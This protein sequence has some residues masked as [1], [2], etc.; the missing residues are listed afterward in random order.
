M[1][2]NARSERCGINA[3]HRPKL[4]SKWFFRWPY[5]RMGTECLLMSI[6]NLIWLT[7]DGFV[8]GDASGAALTSS[9]PPAP[10]NENPKNIAPI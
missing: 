8:F 6:P 1:T 10:K 5:Q 4:Y 2:R 9:H 7:P 3:D